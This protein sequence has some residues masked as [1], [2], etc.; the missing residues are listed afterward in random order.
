[1]PTAV[2]SREFVIDGQYP[3]CTSCNGRIN[4]GADVVYNRPSETGQIINDRFLVR[5]HA[6]EKLCRA[7]TKNDKN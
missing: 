3:P 5:N 2:L 6:G 4:T 7:R 1:M